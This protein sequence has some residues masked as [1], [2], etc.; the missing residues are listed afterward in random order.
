[1]SMS[2]IEIFNKISKER[3]KNH[4]NPESIKNIAT[5]GQIKIRM[6]PATNKAEVGKT[7]PGQ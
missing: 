5:K 2:A 1:M 3:S 4:I 6:T 7:Q